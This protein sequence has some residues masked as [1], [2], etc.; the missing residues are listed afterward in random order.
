MTQE[1]K[2]KEYQKQY[3]DRKM[4]RLVI[5]SQEQYQLLQKVAERQQKPFSTMVRELALAQASNQ[6]VLPLNEQTHEV[7][8]LL[9]RYGTNLNQIAFVANSTRKTPSE[10][11]EKVRANFHEMQTGIM[12][13]YNSP[14]EVKELVRRTLTK[15]PSYAEEIRKVLTQ[16]HDN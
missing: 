15:T 8:I 3:R 10:I 5:F 1:E 16:F 6:Y 4:H 7:K 14:I 9:I 2:Q 11:L 13:I 12:K